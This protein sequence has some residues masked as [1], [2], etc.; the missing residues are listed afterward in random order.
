MEKREILKSGMTVKENL[1]GFIHNLKLDREFLSDA[2]LPTLI[3][4]ENI[5]TL[6]LVI[7]TLEK[8][9]ETHEKVSI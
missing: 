1:E 7:S 8:I 4:Q 6:S 5:K 3:T 9:K 2:I